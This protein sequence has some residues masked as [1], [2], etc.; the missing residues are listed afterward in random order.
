VADHQYGTVADVVDLDVLRT[1]SP[2]RRG[3]LASLADDLVRDLAGVLGGSEDH[4]RKVA[5]AELARLCADEAAYERVAE[6][7]GMLPL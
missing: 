1:L 6:R 5:V 3:Q 4:A 7:R 2:R